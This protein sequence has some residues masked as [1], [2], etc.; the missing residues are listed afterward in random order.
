MQL[1]LG[2]HDQELRVLHPMQLLLSRVGEHQKA[3]IQVEKLKLAM[4]EHVWRGK[5]S[6]QYLWNENQIVDRT[7]LEDKTI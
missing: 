1:Y 3:V 2:E 4:N 6:S 7:T 5:Y